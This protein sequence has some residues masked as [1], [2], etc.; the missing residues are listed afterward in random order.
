MAAPCVEGEGGGGDTAP[1]WGRGGGGGGELMARDVAT[2]WQRSTSALSVEQRPS[3]PAAVQLSNIFYNTTNLVPAAAAPQLTKYS[4]PSLVTAQQTDT[5]KFGRNFQEIY[6][7]FCNYRLIWTLSSNWH[8]PE[9]A[10]DDGD[11][12]DEDEDGDG[13][14]GDH[15][16]QEPRH[17]LGRH[18]RGL[19]R[20]GLLRV[21]PHGLQQ[22]AAGV[23]RVARIRVSECCL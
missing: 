21:G 13:G 5:V 6:G 18:H 9:E 1:V 20:G 10:D 15:E 8:S 16:G 2:A 7:S 11:T 4:V 23:H 17:L 12:E 14:D 19:H 22:R 3:V